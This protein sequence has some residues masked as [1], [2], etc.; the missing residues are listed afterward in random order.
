MTYDQGG[1]QVWRPQQLPDGAAD[2]YASPAPVGSPA[3]AASPA[4]FT[5]PDAHVAPGPTA[6]QGQA[7]NPGTPYATPYGSP[8]PGGYP[9]PSPYAGQPGY[10]PYGP[11]G[12]AM[13]PAQRPSPTLA[14]IGF[15]LS[16][17]MAPIGLIVSITARV[18]GRRTGVGRGLATAGIVVSCLW[19]A[20]AI[21]IPI[22]LDQ[23]L[24]GAEGEG[25][26]EAFGQLQ[27]S[28]VDGDCEAFM[29][30]T[31]ADLRSQIMLNTCDEFDTM[32]ALAGPNTFDGWVPVTDVDV[33]GDE[34]TLWT[35][36]RVPDPS[37]GGESVQTVEYRAI[38]EGDVWLIDWVDLS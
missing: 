22:A 5:P 36:E 25:P 14:I 30:S 32:I 2:P 4:P 18:Q 9:T 1:P 13:A 3:P 17:F 29:T 8:T 37:G 26:R 23:R 35:V 7:P 11:A 19:L 16:I 6:Y 28:L 10:P 21:A 31:T 27:N 20:A 38:R 12:Y 34:A 15:V 33:N 24:G